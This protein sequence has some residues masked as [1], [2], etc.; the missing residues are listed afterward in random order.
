MIG[1][2]RWERFLEWWDKRGSRVWGVLTLVLFVAAV[3]VYFFKI[4]PTA[5]QAA[6]E[7]TVLGGVQQAGPCRHQFRATLS[8][9]KL[10]QDSECN[11]QA[12]LLIY[13][14]ACL[15][16]WLP[17]NICARV[18]GHPP[19]SVRQ[20]LHVAHMTKREGVVPGSGGNTGGLPGPPGGGSPGAVGAGIGATVPGVSGSA[21]VG[22][23]GGT[24]SAQVCVNGA[25]VNCSN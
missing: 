2:T 9:H 19:K 13:N 20:V 22:T 14:G 7:N 24:T 11:L 17:R 16:P 6:R 4:E 1:A 15:H 25:G 12:Y 21:S 18:Q 23:S 8:L 10:K 3:L 5:N